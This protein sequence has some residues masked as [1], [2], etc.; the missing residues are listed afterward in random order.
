[1]P[2]TASSLIDGDVS[3]FLKALHPDLSMM[4]S[5]TSLAFVP[6]ANGSSGLEQALKRSTKKMVIISL[7]MRMIIHG[8]IYKQLAFSYDSRK[9]ITH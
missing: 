9:A 5:V 1:M 6:A 7:S 8:A 3:L 2:S 4:S